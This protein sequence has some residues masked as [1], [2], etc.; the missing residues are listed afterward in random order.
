[1]NHTDIYVAIV[2]DDPDVRMGLSTL[3][4]A[5]D[6]FRLYGSYDS[7]DKA[8]HDI[9]PPLPH[10]V[11]MDINLGKTSG[12]NC[13]KK[14]RQSYPDLTIIMLTVYE[15]NDRIF[16]SLQAGASGYLLKKMP[17][18]MITSAIEE[19]SNGGVPMTPVIAH[20]V[21]NLFK[22]IVPP[23]QNF[24]LTH[25]EKEILHELVR[26][27][28][29]KMVARD[30]NIGIETVRTHMKHIYEKLHVHSKSEAV[31]KALRNR[32]L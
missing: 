19:A 26:G 28:S 11:L 12:I 1:M 31:V 4:N 10:V 30:L 32:I 7:C 9:L 24:N 29:Y 21:L 14:L 23:V 20:K 3:I 15:D 5:T 22:T 25:R 27:S 16:A 13:V 18:E 2:E 6:G 8:V 17:L